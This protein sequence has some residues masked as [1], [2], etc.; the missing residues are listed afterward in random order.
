M[1]VLG[2]SGVLSTTKGRDGRSKEEEHILFSVY[3]AMDWRLGIS[4]RLL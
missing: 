2:V 4:L 3:E 1:K